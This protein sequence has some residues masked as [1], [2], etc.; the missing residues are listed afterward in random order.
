MLFAN[1]SYF[2]QLNPKFTIL[3]LTPKLNQLTSYA[4]FIS[5]YGFMEI[6]IQIMNRNVLLSFIAYTIFH[7][8]Q[9]NGVHA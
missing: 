7:R 8:V 2:M 6:S 1:E 5:R 3:F 4:H 9:R